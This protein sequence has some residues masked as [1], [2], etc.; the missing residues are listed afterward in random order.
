MLAHQARL[1][2]FGPYILQFEQ[3]ASGDGAE[4]EGGAQDLPTALAPGAVDTNEIT[5]CAYP[6]TQTTWRSVCTT[7]TRAAWAAITASIGL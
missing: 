5:H 4:R 3:R 6:F 7:S 1:G 2:P